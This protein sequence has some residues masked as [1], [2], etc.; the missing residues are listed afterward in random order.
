M[1]LLRHILL[2]CLCSAGALYPANAVGE[3]WP[4]Y[5][6]DIHRS[7]VTSEALSVD[8]LKK[9]WEYR[10]PRPPQQAW[11]G[12]AKWDAFS[13]KNNLRSMRN[14]DPVFFTV[15]AGN[16]VFFGSSVE[17]AVFCLNAETGAQIWNYVTGGPVR[18]AP[19]LTDGKLYAGSDDGVAYCLDAATGALIWNYRPSEVRYLPNDGKLISRWPVRSGV[20]V[21][22]GTAYFGA[23]LFPWAD[24]FLCAVDAVS[25]KP[26]GEGRYRKALQGVTIEGALLASRECLYV[27]QGREAPM[28]FRRN[29]GADLG[30]VQDAGGV[31]ALITPE[32]QL[33]FGAP[34]QKD[35]FIAVRDSANSEAVASYPE[36]ICMVVHEDRA[37][38]LRDNELLA[39]NRKDGSTAW[40]AACDC[41]YALILAGDL[42]FTGG[43]NK[44]D[45]FSLTEGASL[46]S[47]PVFGRAHGIT[48]ANSRVFISTDTGSV[49]C[50]K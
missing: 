14:Y 11:H 35:N 25:G 24:A 3:D 46:A 29:D 1:I 50:F 42:L 47:L 22:A 32:N 27:P 20:L 37:Y 5:R 6:H 41:P 44:V 30:T 12:P 8:S 36:G 39:L 21:D 33:V 28:V 9:I 4:T 17:D 10:A 13:G 23:G 48:V 43:N 16:N 40:S 38:V 34:D 26:E 18:M 45:V 7:G 19:M 31:F 2:L 15:A 49:V